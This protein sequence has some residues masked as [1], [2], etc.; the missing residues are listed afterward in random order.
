MLV[1]GEHERPF[2]YVDQVACDKNGYVLGYSVNPG[3]VH[4]SK[5]F[6]PF[7]DEKLSTCQP[8]VICTDA[9]YISAFIAHYLQ[10]KD[11]KLLT[12]YARP[13]ETIERVFAEGKERHGL[14]YTRFKGLKK[15]LQ[16]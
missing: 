6:L 11:I 15:K 14:R 1:K 7:F 12:P 16:Y 8:E 3:N 4:D 9:G 5:A 13:K 10:D 2:A